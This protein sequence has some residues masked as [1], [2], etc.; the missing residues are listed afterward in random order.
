MH[1]THALKYDAEF[2]TPSQGGYKINNNE[3]NW[4]SIRHTFVKYS[5]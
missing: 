5:L 4:K 3:R 2:Q 1:V